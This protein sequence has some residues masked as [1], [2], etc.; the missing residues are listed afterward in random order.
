MTSL[1]CSLF[2]ST[3]TV[4]S[5]LSLDDVFFSPQDQTA[6]EG[7][8]VFF[9]CV[10]G[11]SSPAASISWL[12]DGKPV[13][14][15]R[16]I[17]GEYGGGSQRKTSGTLHLYNITLNDDGTYTC[18]TFNPA[19]GTSKRSRSAKL[20]VQGVQRKLQ[21]IRGPDNI[22]VA[23]GDGAS[24]HC[25]VDGFPVPMVHWFKDDGLLTN[26]SVPLKLQNNGQLLTFRNVS[27]D[28]EGFYHC[29][30]SN[31]KEM[32]K[33]QKGYLLLADM[34][35]SFLKQPVSVTVKR[36]V[37]VTVTCRPP[38][39]WPPALVSWFKNNVLVTPSSNVSVLPSGDLH[40]HSVNEDDAGS[41]F[42]R[43]SNTRLQRFITSRRASITVLAPPSVRLRPQ[44]LTVPVGASVELQCQASGSPPPSINWFKNGHSKQTG[45]KVV[46][47]L[48]HATLY[49]HS[50][51]SYD[52]GVYVCHA[53]NSMGTTQSNAVLKVAVSPI[54]VDFASQVRCRIGSVAI[55]PC[56]AVGIVPITYTWSKKQGNQHIAIAS[57][58]NI[59]TDGEGS[60]HISSVQW[61]D[62]GEYFCMARNHAGQH[63]KR[64]FLKVSGFQLR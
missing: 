63:T 46:K 48:S 60:L 29:E 19:L 36:G 34:N 47:G 42:C 1:L 10:S 5:Q 20:T 35:W 32:V 41:Y 57:N 22:T 56:K 45:G 40:F 21:I 16:Q 28:H 4:S 18:I 13:T 33:S 30:A 61:S 6:H 52:E 51:R 59:Y 31:R 9:P 14:R 38:D 44:V 54:I 26:G 24:M 15:G 64:S 11:E 2:L 17:Q 49:I 7:A 37:N 12:K 58:N 8:T 53:T 62:E 3:L 27:R 55:L 25:A 43:A 39:S 23:T 50:A